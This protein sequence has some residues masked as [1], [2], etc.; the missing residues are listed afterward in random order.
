MTNKTYQSLPLDFNNCTVIRGVQD[1]VYFKFS[2]IQ[3][4]VSLDNLHAGFEEFNDN[5]F[6]ITTVKNNGPK[7]ARKLGWQLKITIINT[8]DDKNP[9]LYIDDLDLEC[10]EITHPKI[11]DKIS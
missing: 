3:S 2:N 6:R 10:K 9:L 1:S 11:Q 8:N 4:S 7:L 5:D